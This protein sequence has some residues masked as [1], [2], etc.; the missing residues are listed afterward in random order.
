MD[1]KYNLSQLEKHVTEMAC[2]VV[3]KIDFSRGRVDATTS[4]CDG[5][6][7]SLAD[8]SLFESKAREI[9]G[10]L[11]FF[12]KLREEEFTAQLRFSPVEHLRLSV[13][14]SGRFI[15]DLQIYN[16]FSIQ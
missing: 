16:G 4:R 2:D 13:H 8:V 5:E 12:D 6:S 14:Q 7:L 1:K 11:E 15:L 10:N 9:I 3:V